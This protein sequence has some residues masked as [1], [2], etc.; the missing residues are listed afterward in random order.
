MDFFSPWT[1]SISNLGREL[2]GSNDPQEPGNKPGEELPSSSWGGSGRTSVPRKEQDRPLSC[3]GIGPSSTAGCAAMQV[4][5]SPA[6]SFAFP[7]GHQ[8]QQQRAFPGGQGREIPNRDHDAKQDPV[9]LPRRNL[10]FS[11]LL[12]IQNTLGN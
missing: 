6:L 7:Q 1:L 4:P 5:Q 3:A 10:R 8:T 9:R 2:E 12:L 11:S